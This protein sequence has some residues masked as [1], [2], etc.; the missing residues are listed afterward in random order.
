LTG[1][2]YCCFGQRW[3]WQETKQAALRFSW[4]LIL[5]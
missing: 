3:I 1:M 5:W 4:F 2:T